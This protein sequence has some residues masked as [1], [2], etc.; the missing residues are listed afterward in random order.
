[1]LVLLPA[2]GVSLSFTLHYFSSGLDT[3]IWQVLALANPMTIVTSIL[4]LLLRTNGGMGY[5]IV[6]V[7]NVAFW[8]LVA[9]LADVLLEKAR[10]R[11]ARRRG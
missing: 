4:S 6:V 5:V 11:R 7:V 1:M 2:Y 10:R 3:V 8:L 9:H